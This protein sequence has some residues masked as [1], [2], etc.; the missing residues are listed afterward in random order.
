M[1]RISKSNS[2]SQT[3]EIPG[4]RGTIGIIGGYS[5]TFCQECNRIRIT[6]AGIL[7]TC[8]YDNG[9]LDLQEMFRNGFSDL[10]IKSAIHEKVMHRLKTGVEAEMKHAHVKISHSMARIGG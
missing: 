6:P 4:F 3:F 5:R 10:E 7:K 2:T 9:V 1:T 8:L